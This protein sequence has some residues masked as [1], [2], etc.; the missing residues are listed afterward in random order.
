MFISTILEMIGLGFIFSIVGSLN[1]AEIKNNPFLNKIINTFEINQSEI[2]LYLLIIFLTFY[3]IKIFFLFFIIGLKVIFLYTFRERL[4]SKVF[5]KY[6]S[7][8]FSFFYSRNSSEFIR[9]LMTEV[10]QLVLYLISILKLILEII[11]VLGIFFLL[12]Y[13]DFKFTI[14]I[15]FTILF[16]SFFY[17]F[18]FKEKLNMWAIQRQSNM[19]KEYNLYKKVLMV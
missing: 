15:T 14:I 7:Q 17:F 13:I 18:L 6:L 12:A 4:S 2:F 19:Q 8:N 9:N 1:L 16:F 5:K 11:I 10:E 3:V